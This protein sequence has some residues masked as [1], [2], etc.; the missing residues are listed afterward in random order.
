MP[1]ERVLKALANQRRLNILRL[2]EERELS[3]M[4]IAKGIKLSIK[5]TSKHLQV[6]AKADLVDK[7]QESL[8]IYYRLSAPQHPV[9][10][11][12]LANL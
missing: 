3:V 8:H 4:H 9:L 6:L 1:L 12:A 5:A 11:V 7:R 2:L 10:G